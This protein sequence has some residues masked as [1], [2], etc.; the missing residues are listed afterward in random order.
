[1]LSRDKKKTPKRKKKRETPCGEAI[2]ALREQAELT[3]DEVTIGKFGEGSVSK[4]HY[5]Q[6]ERGT[7]KP[8]CKTLTKILDAIYH[9]A[10]EKITHEDLLKV[11]VE[12]GCDDLRLPD[13]KAITWA[14]EKSNVKMNEF[15]GPAYLLQCRDIPV[16]FNHLALKL[17][18]A[19]K[20]PELPDIVTTM[21]IHDLLFDHRTHFIDFFQD[22]DSFLWHNYCTIYQY[23]ILF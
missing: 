17:F 10:A 8:N 12:C 7:L 6:Y 9:L 22:R 1:M 11:R 23:L 21:P 3:V 19:D 13:K 14:K 2:T 4:G 20:R 16:D 18:G 15:P 5:S